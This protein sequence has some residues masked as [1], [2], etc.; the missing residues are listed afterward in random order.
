[1][2]SY[3]HYGFE[4]FLADD[5]FQQWV[6]TGSPIELTI[7]QRLIDDFP[8]KK[9]DLD[10]A[11][12]FILSWQGQEYFSEAEVEQG[13]QRILASQ[14]ESQRPVVRWVESRWFGWQI[15]AAIVVL[16][17]VGWSF[18]QTMQTNQSHPEGAY[19]SQTSA[20]LREIANTETSHKRVDL[21]DGSQ[22]MLAPA[23]KIKYSVQMTN[24]LS[25]NVFLT[26]EAVFTVTKNPQKPFMV[27]ANK[28]VVQVVGTSF[29]VKAF[30]KMAQIMVVVHSGKVAV[31]PL[32]SLKA[33]Q[34]S[35]QY[36][37]NKLLLTPNQQAVFD[38]ASERL[39]TG[40]VK[41]PT[42]LR[43][44]ENSQYFVF[45]NAPIAEIFKKLE[46][47][48]GVTISYDNE[49]LKSCNLTVPLSDE[50]LFKKLDIICQ[51]IGATYEVWGTRIVVSGKG[52][53]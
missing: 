7:W 14:K 13:I 17:G 31:F 2:K 25:R 36:I 10:S 19:V 50:P 44:P 46:E 5:D 23:S 30:E 43:N 11:R 34:K 42:L 45:R 22:I 3:K 28:L 24:E 8:E 6:R 21:P 35:Q 33:S 18:W 32:K 38:K 29:T 52:C 47:A 20:N 15:A 39:T 12:E 41:N 53:Q 37:A 4:E 49:A 9:A 26:G 51:T 27:Y 1:M 16:L 40:L 48:Y